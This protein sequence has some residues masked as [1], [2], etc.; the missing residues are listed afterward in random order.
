VFQQIL[1]PSGVVLV[2]KRS[3]QLVFLNPLE[4]LGSL[5]L[6][7]LEEAWAVDLLLTLILGDPACQMSVYLPSRIDRGLLA[8]SGA[9]EHN[10]TPLQY[11]CLAS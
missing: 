11:V 1:Q 9:P 10:A 6:A 4:H 2:H 3:N 8:L 5:D 7:E